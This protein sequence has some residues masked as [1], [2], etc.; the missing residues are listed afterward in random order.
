MICLNLFVS[1][2]VSEA[3][4]NN[5]LHKSGFEHFNSELFEWF[6]LT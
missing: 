1:I 4:K 3:F 5:V 6:S 2:K